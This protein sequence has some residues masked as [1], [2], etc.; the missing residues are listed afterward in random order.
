MT[1]Y[2]EPEL[3]QLLEKHLRN[4]RGAKK[5]ISR[6][7]A[8]KWDLAYK[9]YD[10]A[11]DTPII[12]REEQREGWPIEE[13]AIRMKLH[14]NTAQSMLRRAF[15][16]ING[17]KAT[18]HK[19]KTIVPLPETLCISCTQ[20]QCLRTGKT[21][22]KADVYANQDAVHSGGLVPGKLIIES[23]GTEDSLR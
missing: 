23:I 8:A 16:Q 10:L 19:W 20:R 2:I 1:G 22:A 12:L 18:K 13:I 14:P 11:F 5:R 3:G 6:L 17:T 7:H 9:V 15:E 21:C 4:W